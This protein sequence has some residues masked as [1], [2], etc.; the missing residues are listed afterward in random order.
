MLL[1]LLLPVQPCMVVAAEHGA[2]QALL[3]L[4][5]KADINKVAILGAVRSGK[6]IVAVGER[7]LVFVSDDEGKT[8]SS[9]PAAT[10]KSLTAVTAHG[11]TQ[12]IATGHS[13]L[14]LRSE[15]G[16][17]HWRHPAVPA[18]HKEALLGILALSD[19][20]ILAYGGYASLLESGDGGKSWAQRSILDSEMDKH[21]Y[22]MARHDQSLVLVGE[23]GLISLSNDLGKNWRIVPSPYSGSLFGVTSLPSG[24]FI[25]FG[26]RGKILS[27][28][29]Q[30]Q[31]WSE[32]VSGTKSPFFSATLLKDRRLLLAGK[33]GIL[34]LIS[35][36]GQAVETRHTPDHRTV[37]C[38]V[39]TEDDE[40]LLFGE[41]G[42]RRARWNGLEK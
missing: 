27:S 20:R 31:S 26:M 14:L 28:A 6:R 7:S 33:D 25:A 29:D 8:W 15:D 12:L 5:G 21:F 41:V 42:V 38:V 40:W 18:G 32:L 2:A 37:S 39:E 17:D 13:G 1:S 23:A 11:G 22:G 16:G 9:R 35:A 10:E 19:E 24:V 3:V 34:A 4:K 30:G 36:D